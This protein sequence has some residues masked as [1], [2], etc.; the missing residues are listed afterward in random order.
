MAMVCVIE[1]GGG[2][3]FLNVFAKLRKATI[4]F[5]TSVCLSAWNNSTPTEQ[6]FMKFNTIFFICRRSSR[7][8]EIGQE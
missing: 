7:F 2:E 5:V 4:K 3:G 1:G 8:I 6:I